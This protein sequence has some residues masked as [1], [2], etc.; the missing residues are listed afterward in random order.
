MQIELTNKEKGILFWA[1]FFSLMA[2]GMAF[3]YRALSLGEWGETYNLSGAEL[4]GIVLGS[5][6]WPIAV[7]MILFSLI[8]DFVGYKP[9]MILCFLLHAASVVM[10]YYADNVDAIKYAAITAGF[11][12]GI[13]EAVINPVCASLYKKDKTKWLNILH[14]SWPAGLVVGCIIT[15]FAQ[16]D[17]FLAAE[18][19][20]AKNNAFWVAI[21]TVMYGVMFLISKFPVDERVAAKVPFKDSL[22]DVGFLTSSIAGFFMAHVI[23][24]LFGDVWELKYLVATGLAVGVVFFVYTRS[25]GK[26]LYFILCLL[27]VPLAATE[28]GT[29]GWIQQLMKPSLGEYAAL[30]LALS[31]GIMMVLRFQAGLFTSRFTPPVILTISAVFSTVGLIMLSQVDSF[32]MIVISFAIYAVGQTFYWPTILGLVA[33]QFPKGGAVSLNTVSAIGLLSLGVIGNPVIGAFKDNHAQANVRTVSQE[34]HAGAVKDAKMLGYSYYTLDGKKTKELAKKHD[35]VEE[36]KEAEGSAAKNALFTVALA[37][38]MILGI[39]FLFISLWY[40]SRGGY[41]PV[42]LA[43]GETASSH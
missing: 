6:F 37:F 9:S 10:S 3:A 43:N 32:T 24:G 22:K 33:E 29:D 13:V 25:M 2:S 36:V 21:P 40:K 35:V 39:C 18:G 5:Y 14:A 34:V 4:G 42:E 41:K 16:K 8:V 20:S 28:L 15:F 17:G 12:H 7:T 1:S 19:F 31:A 27:M 11:A 38:P 30:A 26:I 23:S